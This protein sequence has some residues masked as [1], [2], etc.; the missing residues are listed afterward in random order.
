[1]ATYTFYAQ[2]NSGQITSYNISGSYSIAR[3]G[4]G[5]IGAGYGDGSGNFAVG[6]LRSGSLYQVME[7]FVEFDTSSLSGKS[8]SSATLYVWP[9]NRDN[10]ASFTVEARLHDYSTTLTTADFV[11]GSNLSSKTLL[12][13]LADTAAT[14]GA[15]RAFTDVAFP[16]NINKTGKTR[17]VLASSEQRLN[18]APGNGVNEFVYFDQ[19]A[20]TN[21][22]KLVVVTNEAVGDLTKTLANATVSADATLTISGDV[23][24]QLADSTLTTA[25]SLTAAASGNVVKTLANDTI[26]IVVAT[27]THGYLEATL[28]DDVLTTVALVDLNGSVTATLGNATLDAFGGKPIAGTLTVTL[29]NA[30]LSTSTLTGI[31]ASMTATLADAV[32][33]AAQSTPMWPTLEDFPQSPLEGTWRPVMSDDTLRSEREIGARQ[34]RS[35]NGGNYTQVSFSI[36]LVTR[37]QRI[38]FDRFFENDCDA[39]TRAFMWEDPE[40]GDLSRFL[41]N[42]PPV[43]R[44][45]NGIHFVADCELRKEAA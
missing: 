38:E 1:M 6:Q 35:R 2:A 7:N 28:A 44:D 32:L 25:G 30:T 10:D 27:E 5:S 42:S 3:Q 33:S 23:T 20:D 31:T 39:G 9:T 17:I 18:S 36:E 34:T 8:L 12:A 26:S 14:P 40:T 15:Y 11:S 22:V 45:W 43:V 41:W 24:A 16:A 29:G 13:T 4:T 37:D 21:P 19:Y